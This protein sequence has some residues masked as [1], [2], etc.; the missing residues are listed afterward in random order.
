MHQQRVASNRI[1]D[2]TITP[3]IATPLAAVT[4]AL[5]LGGLLGCASPGPPPPEAGY[6]AHV[7]VETSSP[8][9]QEP[10]STE[11]VEYY[12]KQKRR[13]ESR[14][15]DGL[16]VLI[17]RPDLR[18]SWILNPQEK[19]F[20]EYEI[21]SPEVVIVAIPNPFGPR[22]G[23]AFERIG[24]E[25][26]DDVDA[27]KYSV[28][29]EAISGLAWFSSDRV[30]MR[31]SGTVGPEASALKVE[32]SYTDIR[33]GPQAAYL[34]AIPPTYEGYAE[35]KQ[36]SA[37]SSSKYDSGRGQSVNPSDL[38]SGGPSY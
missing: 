4:L 19:T 6:R 30:P 34:F 25:R 2:R 1:H 33:R 38:P 29:G 8:S 12:Y 7:R 3:V 27:E 10:T 11:L 14:T 22:S 31:F 9:G 23:A 20:E 13:Q 15:A 16:V 36:K 24:T 17:D 32:I 5:I 18:I 37:P 21:S 35:R 26:I 28:Q